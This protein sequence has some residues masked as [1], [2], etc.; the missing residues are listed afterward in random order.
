MEGR[1]GYGE[2]NLSRR[3]PNEDAWARKTVMIMSMAGVG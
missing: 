2:R 1:V 3:L